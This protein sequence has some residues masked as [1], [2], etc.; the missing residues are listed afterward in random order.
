MNLS[1]LKILEDE[2]NFN[3]N[4]VNLDEEKGRWL[5]LVFTVV[6]Y[7]LGG[8]NVGDRSSLGWLKNLEDK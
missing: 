8:F 3:F 5:D 2:E 4:G 6:K 1:S 7:S